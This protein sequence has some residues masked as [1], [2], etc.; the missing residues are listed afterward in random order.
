MGNIVNN[1]TGKLEKAILVIHGND[2][3]NVTVS[4]K[5]VAAMAKSALKSQEIP[6]LMGARIGDPQVLQVQYNPTSLSIQGNAAAIP[7]I[8][9]QQNIDAGVPNQMQRPPMVALTVDLFFDAMNPRDAFMFDKLNLSTLSDVTTG[10]ARAV[11]LK[12]GNYTVQHQTNGLLATVLR[13]ESRVV[14]FAWGSLAFTGVLFE[15]QAEYTMFSPS[16]RPVRSVVRM[17]IAQ[18]VDSAVDTDYWEKAL[19]KVFNEAGVRQA[20][21]ASQKGGNLINMQSLKGLI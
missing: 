12:S 1:M 16:G 8:Q 14:T 19:D 13:P 17:N 2:T 18:Q 11:K 20:M 7:Y 21:D 6:A 5:N 15:M 4:S 3:G 10:V 9:M